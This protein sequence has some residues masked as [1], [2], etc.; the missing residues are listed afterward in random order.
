MKWGATT[1]IKRAVFTTTSSHSCCRVCHLMVRPLPSP[2]LPQAAQQAT[3]LS[4][5]TRSSEGGFGQVDM[6]WAG[7]GAAAGAGQFS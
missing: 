6:E 5:T 7:A 2:L 3:L 4:S 1:T